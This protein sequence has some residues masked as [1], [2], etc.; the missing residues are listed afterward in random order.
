MDDNSGQWGIGETGGGLLEFETGALRF[1][2]NPGR[3]WMW[4]HRR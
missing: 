2:V 4:S 1:D 3:A